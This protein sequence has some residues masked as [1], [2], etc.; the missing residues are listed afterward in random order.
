MLKSMTILAQDAP[1][2]IPGTIT[3]AACMAA[4]SVVILAWRYWLV[5]QNH[6]RAKIVE[7]E[8]LTPEEAERRGQELGAQNVT[9]L[10]NPYFVYVSQKTH[11]LL[12]IRD[13]C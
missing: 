8:G 1:H 7:A 9:D 10:K 3:M 5:Y 11:C 13:Y 6:K 4:Q 12:S 2:Y